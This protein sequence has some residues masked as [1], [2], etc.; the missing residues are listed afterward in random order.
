VLAPVV[1][2]VPAVA[3]APALIVV[4]ILM[5]ASISDI[6][7]HNFEDA[8]VA[9]L[10]VIIMPFSYNITNGIAFGFITYVLIKLVKGKLKEVHPIM[11]VFTA[12]FILNF[13]LLAISN[14]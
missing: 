1:G 3:T 4:G 8:A 13:I 9:F 11:Y 7:W 2:L 5:M 6:D 10:A 14:V 12:L